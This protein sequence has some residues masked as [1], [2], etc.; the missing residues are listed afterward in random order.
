[1]QN[2][3]LRSKSE[4]GV[5]VL[6]GCKRKRQAEALAVFSAH[7]RPAYQCQNISHHALSTTASAPAKQVSAAAF[8]IHD[9][10][11]RPTTRTASH[12]LQAFAIAST[13]KRVSEAHVR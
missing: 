3:R 13:S 11:C 1:M 4:A 9:V 6:R 12:A 5:F 10:V 7:S 2:P 8:A